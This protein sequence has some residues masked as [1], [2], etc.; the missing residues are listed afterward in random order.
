MP[1]TSPLP[2]AEPVEPLET[3]TSV[4]LPTCLEESGV[5]QAEA[6]EP[7]SVAVALALASAKSAPEAVAVPHHPAERLPQWAEQAAPTVAVVVAV[8]AA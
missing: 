5:S 1:A 2:Q 8:V 3:P 6:V 4:D 7:I